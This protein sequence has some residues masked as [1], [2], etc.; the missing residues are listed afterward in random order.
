MVTG[1]LLKLRT[2]VKQDAFRTVQKLHRN[3]G[4]PAPRPKNLR[5]Y[6]LLVAPAIKSLKRQEPMSVLHAPS[7]RSLL[8]LHPLL[9]Q[10]QRP[11]IRP[12][13]GCL[14]A[15]SGNDQIPYSEHG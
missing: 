2:S 10:L 1:N 14:L 8:M 5:S 11:S 13:G 9:C 7:T 12:C 6:L 15:A 4:H 3:L